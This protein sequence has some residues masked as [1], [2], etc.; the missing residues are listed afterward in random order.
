MLVGSSTSP[1][2]ESVPGSISLAKFLL[3]PVAALFPLFP[4]RPIRPPVPRDAQVIPCCL[5][6]ACTL[7]GF[8][9][10]HGKMRCSLSSR[11]ER[12]KRPLARA[13]KNRNSQRART[14]YLL[15]RRES[16]IDLRDDCGDF[17]RI[18]AFVSTRIHRGCNVVVSLTALHA[19]V[20]IANSAHRRSVDPRVRT[21][22]R[23][24]AVNVVTDNRCC[25]RTPIQGDR[26]LHGWRNPGSAQ[27]DRLRTGGVAQNRR[28]AARQARCRRRELHT[29]GGALIRRERHRSRT[30]HNRISCASG[31][32]ARN[33]NVRTAGVGHRKALCRSTSVV[34]AAKAQTAWVYADGVGSCHARAAQRDRCGRIRGVAENRYGAADAARTLRRILYVEVSALPGRQRQGGC[35]AAQAEPCPGHGCLRN[36]Q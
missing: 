5:R 7:L 34:D 15:Q 19:G 36:R 17:V 2:K 20:G 26:M 29:H 1:T 4:S 9:L 31:G 16:T 32:Y 8:A 33:R 21:P 27:R 10:V 6:P 30:A 3:G 13:P 22:A 23:R 25:A 28:A 35:Q 18:D 24:A 11:K 12:L 14:E